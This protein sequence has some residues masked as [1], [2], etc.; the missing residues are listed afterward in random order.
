MKTP[1]LPSISIPPP[2]SSANPLVQA[3]E[4][5][6]RSGYVV[7][8][9]EELQEVRSSTSPENHV[10]AV[11]Y[12]DK[13]NKVILIRGDLKTIAMPTFNFPVLDLENQPDFTRLELE[14]FGLTLKAGPGYSISVASL[15]A[16]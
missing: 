5:M 4:A 7:L 2:P 6:E 12:N 1:F 13:T 9:R 14:D 15:I 11:K 8:P 16:D 3:L 10:V